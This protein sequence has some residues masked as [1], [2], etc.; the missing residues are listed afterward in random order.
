MSSHVNPKVNDNF[1]EW[2]NHKYGK[3]GKMKSNRGKLHEYL[4]I[5]SDFTEKVKIKIKMDDYVEIM[6]NKFPM[7]IYK[8]DTDL[9]PAGNNIFEK[10]NSKRLSEK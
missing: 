5:T 2:M 3:H 8:S 10:V 4:G 7:K 6:I 9:T 1:K